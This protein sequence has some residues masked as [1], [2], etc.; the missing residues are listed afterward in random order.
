MGGA[1]G[2]GEDQEGRVEGRS[3]LRKSNLIEGMGIS[4]G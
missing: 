2:Q 1:R 4:T 3:L